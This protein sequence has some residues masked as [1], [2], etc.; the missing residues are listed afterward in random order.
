MYPN[1]MLE[2][3]T[4]KLYFI[5]FFPEVYIE[6]SLK[7]HMY[8]FTFNVLQSILTQYISGLNSNAF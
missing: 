1:K 4:K 2:V 6:Y 7:A 3:H 8:Q 5:I